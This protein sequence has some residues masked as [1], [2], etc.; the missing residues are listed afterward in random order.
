VQKD[1]ET[2]LQIGTKPL[3]FNAPVYNAESYHQLIQ[4]GFK[5]YY[6]DEGSPPSPDDIIFETPYDLLRRLLLRQS[7]ADE[8]IQWLRTR[9]RL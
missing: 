1:N 2:I 8:L 6:G 4:R 9:K 5:T 7:I 3:Q